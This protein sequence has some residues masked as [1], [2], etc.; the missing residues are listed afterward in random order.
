MRAAH[1]RGARD[2]SYMRGAG[3]DGRRRE[4]WRLRMRPGSDDARAAIAATGGG[5]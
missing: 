1:A 3:G 4:A 5:A 2:S